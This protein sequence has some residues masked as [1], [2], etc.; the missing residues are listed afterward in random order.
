MIITAQAV[1]F[2]LKAQRISCL[3]KN[4][5]APE[6]Q[7]PLKRQRDPLKNAYPLTGNRIDFAVFGLDQQLIARDDRLRLEA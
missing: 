6:H 7:E 2:R 1:E 3:N 5:T 4:E